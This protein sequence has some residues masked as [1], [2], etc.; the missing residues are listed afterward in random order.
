MRFWILMNH[1]VITDR[2]G[3]AQW[4][5]YHLWKITKCIVAESSVHDLNTIFSSV[6]GICEGCVVHKWNTEYSDAQIIVEGRDME[7][8]ETCQYS[9][10]N[11]QFKGGTI[12]KLLCPMSL[13]VLQF[14]FL[15][16]SWW[17]IHQHW[18]VINRITLDRPQWRVIRPSILFSSL[19]H[20]F[21]HTVHD[22]PNKAPLRWGGTGWSMNE[23]PG[24]WMWRTAYSIL[25]SLEH[26]VK[27]PEFSG[28]SSACYLHC[29]IIQPLHHLLFYIHAHVGTYKLHEW[30]DWKNFIF[31]THVVVINFKNKRL[32]FIWKT[33]LRE[34]YIFLF[35][36]HIIS[37]NVR[38]FWV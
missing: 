24:K 20:Y 14:N 22:Q 25:I 10:V 7:I 2:C 12:Y 36:T 37:L 38:I 4:Q 29:Y 23:P 26:T 35:D 5:F 19:V 9:K 31:M 32:R 17:S 1:L 30:R 13:L 27:W 6:V 34:V 11:K 3:I 28:N 16:I 18:C 21:I 8:G 33:G 15:L